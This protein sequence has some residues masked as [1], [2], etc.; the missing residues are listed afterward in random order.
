MKKTFISLCLLILAIVASQS[1]AANDKI[2]VGAEQPEKYLPLLKG[3]RIGLIVNQTAVAN[4]QHLVDLLQQNNIQVTT[5]FAPEH[6]IR[7][8]HDAGAWV[9]NSVDV[10]SGVPIISLYGK[11]KRPTHAMLANVDVLV[12]DIQDVGVRFYTYINTMFYAM[13]AAQALNKPF[14]ILDRPNPHIQ[15]IDGPLLDPGF[16]SFVGLMPIPMSHGMTVGELGKMMQGEQWLETIEPWSLPSSVNNKKLQLTV[17]PVKNY[18]R[19]DRYVLPIA[20]SPNLPNQA[21]VTLYPS[22]CL[23][24]ATPVSIGRGTDTPF[25][26]IGHDKISIGDHVFRPISMPGKSKFPKLENKTA[27][28]Q[29]VA[30]QEIVEKIANSEQLDLSYLMAWHREFNKHSETFFSRADFFDQLAGTDELRKAILSGKSERQIR[31]SWQ[32]GLN[33]FKQRRSPYLIYLIK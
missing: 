32:P 17:V 29:F 26:V 28:G 33:E 22:L 20:P 8:G 24:E 30:N 27:K 25:Q 9:K 23:F 18:T 13:Q 21:A 31:N 4:G 1:I 6:G 7:G 10:K 15:T 16:R 12:F 11:N 2:I 14:I 19:T 5:L 3:K